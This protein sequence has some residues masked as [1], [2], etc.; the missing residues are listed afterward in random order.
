[1]TDPPN[2]TIIGA[3]IAGLT[4]ARCLVEA[5]YHVSVIDKGRGVGGRMATRRIGDA[6]LDH[7]AQFFTVRTEPFRQLVDSAIDAGVVEAW[8]NGFSNND[9]HARYVCPNGM[10]AL[11]KWMAAELAERGVDI[12]LSTKATSII[13]DA[14][15]WTVETEDGP[16]RLSQVLLSTAPVPQTLELLSSGGTTVAAEVDEVLRSIVYEPIFA[17]LVTLDGPSAVP[18]PGGM[19]QSADEMF[20]FIGDN[21]QKRVSPVPAITF[22]L[23]STI[24]AQRW[25]D[26]NDAIV[27]DV[28]PKIAPWTG[29]ANV[30]DVQLHKWK[31]ASLPE[32]SPQPHVVVSKDPGIF[33]VAG[34]A[35][36]TAKVEGAFT[37]G[38]SAAD[39]IVAHAS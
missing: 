4:A 30:V 31:Y 12:A 18:P 1:V 37:S 14:H 38:M 26:D 27:A 25:H 36:A 21:H 29:N 15:G 23:N 5:G 32:P 8:C 11:T 2:A 10:T 7:G 16:S 28:L 39:A 13:T 22:H 33:V 9:G 34:D 19:Q 35:F 24:S 20:T 6:R 3:G 17:L